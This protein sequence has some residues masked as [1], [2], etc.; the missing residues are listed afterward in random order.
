MQSF[1]PDWDHV[2]NIAYS[3]AGAATFNSAPSTC[4]E[5]GV[6]NLVTVHPLPLSCKQSTPSKSIS[7]NED[8]WI[9]GSIIHKVNF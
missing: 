2:Q 1:M 5:I 6:G 8:L 7:A 3:V 4:M 9:R